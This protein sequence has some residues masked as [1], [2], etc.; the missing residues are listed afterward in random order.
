MLLTESILALAAVFVAVISPSVGSC[1]FERLERRFTQLARQRM[2]S[3]AAVGLLALALRAAL[4]PILPIPKALVQDEFSYLL[5]ADAFSH[6][7][8]TNPTH[9]LWVHFETFATI[10]QPTYASKYPPAQGL[11]LALG[12]VLTGEPFWGVWL[13]LGLMAAAICWMLQA[14]LSPEWALFGGLLAVMRI[15]TFSYWANSYWG[16]TVAA[17]GGALVF[18]ALPRIKQEIRVRHALLF[19]AGLAILANSRPYE[20]LGCALM[21]MLNLLLWICSRNLNHLRR[22]AAPLF[23]PLALAF[24]AGA[25]ALAGYCWRVTGSP[26]RMPYKVYQE[27][28]DPTPYFVWQ[29]PRPL[30]VYRHAELESWELGRAAQFAKFRTISG[31]GTILLS[32]ALVFWFFYMGPLFTVVI[33][34]M[35]AISSA[36]LTWRE[37]DPRT[38]FL[39]ISALVSLMG[40]SLE[41]PSL[42]H[43]AAPITCLI[44]ALLLRAMDYIRASWHSRGK[45][46]GQSAVRWLSAAAL[47]VFL[48]RVALP[49]HLPQYGSIQLAS[50]YTG[51]QQASEHEHIASELKQHPG[52]HL[53]LLHYSPRHDASNEWVYNQADIDRS[54][55]VWARDMGAE[56]NKELLRYYR[57]RCVW[58]RDAD[59]ASPKLSPYHRRASGEVI[60]GAGQT[61]DPGEHL[62]R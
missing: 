29:T 26:L 10:Q 36:N 13:S 48:L 51:Q 31:F 60:V 58:L 20:G 50:W 40:L 6:G 34:L 1:W 14:W 28:Y 18:G 12:Q 4:L 21:A 55:I 33:L 43:Y 25:S 53:V 39:L 11:M 19:A 59:D 46:T 5:A 56:Q 38:S 44:Y 16:G 45:P 30:P 2:L 7:R 15:G 22:V 8:L 49:S 61:R 27:T 35:I 42:P 3:V 47:A 41:V 9:P 32:K 52:S 37:L 57:D 54:R 62:C 24:L 23:V 17:I